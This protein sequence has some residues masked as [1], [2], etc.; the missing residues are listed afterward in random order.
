MKNDPT[1]NTLDNIPPALK[2]DLHRN[3][4]VCN[5]VPKVDIITAIINGATTVEEVLKQ[6][7]ATDGIGC[8]TRQVERLIERL[9]APEI[10]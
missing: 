4:C 10:K 2:K 7:Y 3:L 6:T 8:C 9:R 1:E 5:D